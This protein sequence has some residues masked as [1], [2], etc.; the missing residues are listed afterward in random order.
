MLFRKCPQEGFPGCRKAFQEVASGERPNVFFHKL[1]QEGFP[2]SRECGAAEAALG[3]ALGGAEIPGRF[4]GGFLERFWEMLLATEFALHATWF[5]LQDF[6]QV[7]SGSFLGSAF[8]K[9]S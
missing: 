7:A 1:L 6:S 4:L 3:G 2:A 8:R 5:A 9:A